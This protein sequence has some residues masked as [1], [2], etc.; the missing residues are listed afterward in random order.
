MIMNDL[1]YLELKVKL[2]CENLGPE[3]VFMSSSELNLSTFRTDS[4]RRL[5]MVKTIKRLSVTSPYQLLSFLLLAA[6]L[7]LPVN[8]FAAAFPGPD[9]FGY[10]GTA[11][12]LN[13]RDISTTG[14]DV[15]LDGTDDVTRTVTIG[16]SFE[17]YGATYT[18]IIISSN[19]FISFGP[20]S[21]S[22][23][24]NGYPIPTA[25]GAENYIA[26]W[27]TDLYPRSGGIIRTQ[28]IGTTGNR[29]F[30]IGFYDVGFFGSA[31]TRNTFEIILHEGSN[32]VEIA[33]SDVKFDGNHNMVAGIENADGSDGIEIEFVDHSNTTYSDGDSVISNQGYLF[34][35]TP[36][37][38]LNEWGMI[39][40]SLLMA[41]TAVWFIKKENWQNG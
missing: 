27:W 14:T 16:F 37:P 13:L 15:G 17:F 2:R 30:I 40:F 18:Q 22:H 9:N 23:C 35:I 1:F 36:I 4:T 20:G 25:G 5:K 41:G 38:T 26:G 21:S 39:I 34:S 6:L 12:P 11:I 32:N 3:V 28:L 29:E 10:T 33:I 19:G 24:C 8:V 31:S 7:I